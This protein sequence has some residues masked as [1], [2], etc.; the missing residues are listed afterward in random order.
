MER[1]SQPIAV[2]FPGGRHQPN[3]ADHIVKGSKQIACNLVR[4]LYNR[5]RID[6]TNIF[7]GGQ[8]LHRLIS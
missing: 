5:E 4:Y 7:S 8:T 2:R 6:C 3:L 1:A